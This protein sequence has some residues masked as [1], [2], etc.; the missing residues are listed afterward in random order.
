MSLYFFLIKATLT[1]GANENMNKVNGL[2]KD[3][4]VVKTL[5]IAI[6][7]QFKNFKSF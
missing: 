2:L 5:F 4:E 6:L 7:P 1:D 3:E